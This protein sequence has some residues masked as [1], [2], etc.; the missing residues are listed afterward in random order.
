MKSQTIAVV[1]VLVLTGAVTALAQDAPA[2]AGEVVALQATI[3]GVEGLVQVRDNDAAAWRKAEVGLVLPESA[4][5]RTGPRSAVRF[6]I[7]PAQTVTLDRLGTV[8]LVQAVND[9]GKIKTNLGMRYGRTRYDVE[10]AGIEHESSISSP[11]T[12]LA[13]RGTKVSLYDQPP[14]RPEA[15]SLTGRAVF[16]DRRKKVTIGGPG[17]GK[18]KM[19]A[20]DASPADAALSS[21]VSDPIN[22]NARSDA[23][24]RLLNTIIAGGANVSVDRGTGL[25]VVTG[26]VP[27]SDA[28]LIPSLPGTLNF[29][30]RWETNAN[31]DL[32]VGAPGGPNNAG[33]FLYPAT[34]LT[35]TRSGG[36]VLWD[37]QG[38]PNGGIEV[39]YWPKDYPSGIYGL[40]VILVK[41]QPTAA[42][43]DAFENGKRIPIF[44]GSQ[45][46][47]SNRIF[48]T[49]PIPGISEGTL[50]GLVPIRAEIPGVGST[51]G[52]R[53]LQHV[54]PVMPPTRNR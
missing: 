38:G 27:P 39:A 23:E 6:T 47:Q 52:A 43:V 10:A 42:T 50:G 41:G 28:Q 5:F 7:P 16:S 53:K 46:V 49:P 30:L 18:A 37:H 11:S 44:D 45:F 13:V 26:G 17:S 32:G 25:R 8:K 12:T 1:V 35:A 21:T 22:D 40:G 36:R 3:T 19:S 31:L 20:G 24:G 9:N 54:G 2:P 14:F 48:V 51:P 34:G 4:E 33:E 15:V 29:V